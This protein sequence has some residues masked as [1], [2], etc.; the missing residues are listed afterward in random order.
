M[1]SWSPLHG[2]NHEEGPCMELYLAA[3]MLVRGLQSSW[4]VLSAHYLSGV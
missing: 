2:S 3:T 4:A 1:E